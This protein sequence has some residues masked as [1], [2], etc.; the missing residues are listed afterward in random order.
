MIFSARFGGGDVEL[1]NNHL[2]ALREMLSL[3]A[4]S[5]GRWQTAD[6]LTR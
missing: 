5:P 6:A 2:E 3:L 4:P 1:T